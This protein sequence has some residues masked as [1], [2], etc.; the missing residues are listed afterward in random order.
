MYEYFKWVIVLITIILDRQFFIYIIIILKDIH[1]V[2]KSSRATNGWPI[3][4]TNTPIRM[5]DNPVLD[6]CFTTLLTSYIVYIVNIIFIYTNIYNFLFSCTVH[7]NF[8]LKRNF[9]FDFLLDF[10]Y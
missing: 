10:F 9:F 5:Q 1:R 8:N 2:C 3:R 4:R 6:S 7:K